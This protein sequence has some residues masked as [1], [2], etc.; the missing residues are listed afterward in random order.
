M[1][2][3][4]SGRPSSH[5]IDG[6]CAGDYLFVMRDW[7]LDSGLARRISTP[8]LIA[9]D[10]ARAF[11]PPTDIEDDDHAARRRLSPTA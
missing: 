1:P 11:C 4:D 5:P 2:P 7:R 8:I 9:E 3:S 6:G 10:R